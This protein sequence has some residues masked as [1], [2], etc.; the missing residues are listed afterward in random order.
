MRITQLF[1]LLLFIPFLNAC[2][3][4]Q[5]AAPPEGAGAPPAMPVTVTKPVVKEVKEWDSFSGRFEAEDHVEIRAR[6]SGY[7]DQIH[8]KDGDVV[9]KGQLLFTI[10]PRPFAADKNEADAGVNAA[11]TRL[12]LADQQLERAEKLLKKEFGSQEM[13][14]Q[15]LDEKRRAEADV[16]AARARLERINLDLEFT[17]IKAPIGGRISESMVDVGNL[18]NTGESL[19]ATIVSIDPIHFYFDVDEKTYLKYAQL[20]QDGTRPSSR[21]T[22]NPVQVTVGEGETARTFDGVMDFVDNVM[23][24][25]TGTMRGRALI[26]NAD[27]FL[28]PGLFG[29]VRLQGSGAY[30][31]IL[32]PDEAVQVD[33]SRSFVMIVKEDGTVEPRNVI[34]GTK[35]EGLRVVTSGLDGAEQIIYKGVQ[36]AQPGAKV[37]PVL[38]QVQPVV[39][40][41]QPIVMVPAPA[42]AMPAASE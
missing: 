11:Q 39:E 23:D 26:P 4:S 38:E 25:K 20:A 41:A 19:L 18:V 13:Y 12:S 33:Q 10:D 40:G 29:R 36:R 42:G 17:Q 32:I 28:A 31:A 3:Q 30:T 2:D 16:K 15:R 6:V 8:F 9:E 37:S 1:L 22:A 34:L 5:A 14:D 27:S 7:L 24:E 21:T 35:I